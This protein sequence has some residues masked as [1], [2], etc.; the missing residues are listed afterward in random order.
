MALMR[1]YPEVK[2]HIRARDCLM[3]IGDIV[4][5]GEREI[6]VPCFKP[7]GRRHQSPRPRN[8]HH[9]ASASGTEPEGVP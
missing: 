6:P 9:S 2:V 8:L 3:D 1:R 7:Q 4:R 5:I